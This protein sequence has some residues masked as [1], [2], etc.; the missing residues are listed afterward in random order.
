MTTLQAIVLGLVQGLT[1]FLPISS[2]AHLILGSRVL[3]WPDQGLRF[4]MAAN[5]GSLIAVVVYL[6]HELASLAR[7]VGDTLRRRATGEATAARQVV[8]AT[9]PV[10]VAGLL[11]QDFIAADGRSL[12]VLGVTSLVF[13]VLLAWA[14]RLAP[15]AA[16]GAASGEAWSWRSVAWVGLAQ[17][18]ALFPGTS[19]SGVTM[20][21][22][23][24]SGMSREQ[25]TRLSFVLAVP[26][27]LL[28]AVK[29]G[30]DLLGEPA[31]A[32]DWAIQVIGSLTAAIS[33]YAAIYWL[34]H[35]VKR[36]GFLPFA[37]YRVVL[38][39]VLL[40]LASL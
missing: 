27:G 10:A 22:G 36:H 19:R 16:S 12:T 5:S 20:T 2:S 13:G 35:W 9:I 4:D 15:R 17:A 33:A 28:V 38:G 34:L 8:V 14:D 40:V 31:V 21:A 6:R 11:L 24:F 37:V 32:D 3:G 18:L 25:A 7:G 23:L 1:E 29:D 30:W 39:I 26:V